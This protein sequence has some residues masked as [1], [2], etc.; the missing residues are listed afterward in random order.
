MADPPMADPPMA[1]ITVHPVLGPLP[2]VAEVS[3]TFR[4]EVISAREGEPIGAALMAAGIVALRRS[5]V[6]GEPRG[7][8]CAIGHCMECRVTV[9]G[10]PGVRACLTPVRGGEV[11]E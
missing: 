7:I 2:D 3:F 9:D 4:G 10:Q 8:F 6:S 1:R 5:E 11:V